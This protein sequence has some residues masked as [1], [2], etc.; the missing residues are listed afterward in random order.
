MEET[1][2]YMGNRDKD[3]ETSYAPA[4][5]CPTVH[6]EDGMVGDRGSE[7]EEEPEANGRAE[8]MAHLSASLLERNRNT[9]RAVKMIST[10]EQAAPTSPYTRLFLV[11][12]SQVSPLYH[13]VSVVRQLR[14]REGAGEE[15]E[16]S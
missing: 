3:L 14:W 9:K 4:F 5:C 12:D 1:P 7:K 16:Q 6:P 11:L 13:S 8:A 15:R 10:S 2:L